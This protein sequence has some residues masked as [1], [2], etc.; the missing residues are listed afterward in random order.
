MSN[1]DTV[2]RDDR[3]SLLDQLS[4][5][6]RRESRLRARVKEASVE[7][8][9]IKAAGRDDLLA[10]LLRTYLKADVSDDGTAVE[11]YVHEMGKPRMFVPPGTATVRRMTAADLI[12][13]IRKKY[14]IEEAPATK[15]SAARPNPWVKATFNLTDQ[16][17]ITKTDPALAAAMKAQ[18]GVA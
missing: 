11:V 14:K 18:A 12:P 6:K 5:S 9:A 1:T 7:A 2:D 13:E 17:R 3:D 8:A 16:M 15:P 4:A 10:T